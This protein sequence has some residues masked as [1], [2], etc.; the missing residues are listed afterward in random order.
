MTSACARVPFKVRRIAV[1]DAIGEMPQL[2]SWE[3]RL[4]PI[5]LFIGASGFEPRVLAVPQLLR[6]QGAKIDNALLGRYGTNVSDNSAREE[7]LLPVIHGLAGAHCFFD[8]ESPDAIFRSIERALDA[9]PISHVLFDISGSS[10][11][12]IFS[13]MA[14]LLR[15]V[16]DFRLTI[17]YTPAARYHE[18]TPVNRDKPAFIWAEDELRECGVAQ[19]DFNELYQGI[20]QDNL[21]GYVIAYPSM[22]PERLQRCLTHLGVAPLSG[23]A[24][25][26][27][28]WILPSF[29]DPAH[30]WRADLIEKGIA[31]IFSFASGTEGASKGGSP[32][33]QSTCGVF[34]YLR[35][36]EIVMQKVDEYCGR[37]NVSL[38]HSGTK[39]QAIGAAIALAARPE[40][41]LVSAR[42][43]SFA[44]KIY[45]EGYGKTHIIEFGSQ[46]GIVEKM[47][48]VG[49]LEAVGT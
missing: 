3:N 11:R 15:R 24:E 32:G 41:A 26:S 45:S 49:T 22:Y 5:S 14:T 9:A 21:P 27:V 19:V 13:V 25:S 23:G 30:Q 46:R 8:A 33:M 29:S 39:L 28:H 2:V 42:P 38:V 43:N 18:P 36:A 17:A 44:A 35:S 6:E 10:S 16:A 7:Q 47:S 34:D 37:A 40:V 12:L 31:E 4:P 1:G 48:R 20:H